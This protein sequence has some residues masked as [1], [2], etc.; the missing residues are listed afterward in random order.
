MD[1]QLNGMDGLELTRRLKSEAATRDILVVAMTAFEKET[2][3]RRAVAAGCD[4]FIAKPFPNRAL[5]S[6]VAAQLEREP[7][8]T[9]PKY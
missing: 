8:A 1:I 5:V 3:E 9:N 4:G 2:A 6:L 7:P